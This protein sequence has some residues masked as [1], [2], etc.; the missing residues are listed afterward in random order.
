MVRIMATALGNI[1]VVISC[2]V[3]PDTAYM[4]EEELQLNGVL[5]Y[6]THRAV[7]TSMGKCCSCS[8]GCGLQ[9]THQGARGVAGSASSRAVCEGHA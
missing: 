4:T 5:S 2:K 7:T 6:S 8:C 9:C 1:L 3:M